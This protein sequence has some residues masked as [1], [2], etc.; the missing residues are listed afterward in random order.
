[1]ANPSLKTKKYAL[2]STVDGICSL[3]R[4]I[5]S[6]GRI[7]RL[8]LDTEDSFVR[9]QQW[10]E[11]TGLE[12]DAVSWDGALRNVSAIQEYY[13]DGATSFQVVVD[14]MLLA[15]ESGLTGVCWATGAEHDQLLRRW[16]DV[17]KRQLPVA[18]ID[19]LLGLPV[20]RLKS[21]PEETL[22]LCCSKYRNSD[23]EDVSMAIKTSIEF[24]RENGTP[25]NEDANRSGSHP[26]E[27]GSATSQLVLTTGGL[28][29]VAWGPPGEAGHVGP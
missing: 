5:L 27:H 13:S 17:D 26:Q 19:Q 7:K 1:M 2:P 20:R 9:A 22:I 29:R 18:Q 21:L 10:T 4:E 25:G 16:F 24:R 3:V 8:E 15:Q 23:P 12:E 28:R 11:N 14:M 6:E